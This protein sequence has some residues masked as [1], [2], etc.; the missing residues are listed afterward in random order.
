MESGYTYFPGFDMYEPRETT[1]SLEKWQERM[2]KLSVDYAIYRFNSRRQKQIIKINR[3][4]DSYNGITDPK[5]MVWLNT[6]YG[7][8]NLT[9]YVDYRLART[10]VDLIRGE[11][12]DR[13]LNSTVYTINKDAQSE[14]LQTFEF[15]TGANAARPQLDKLAQAGY[16]VM[17][18][19]QIPQPDANGKFNELDVKTKNEVIMQYLLNSQIKKLDMKTKF[20]QNYLDCLTAAECYSKIYINDNGYLK[21]RDIDVRDALYEEIERDPFL[22]QSP[23]LGERRVMFIPDIITE[24]V[25][26]TKADRDYLYQI[27]NGPTTG[28]IT[29]LDG[30][31]NNFT[32]IGSGLAA[33]VYTIEWY[34]V[35]PFF[36]KVSPDKNG[37]DPYRKDIDANEYFSDKFQKR[38]KNESKKGVTIETKYKKVLWEATRISNDIYTDIREKANIIANIDN[39][40]ETTSSYSGCI[41]NMK[42]GTRVSLQESIENVSRTYNTVMFQINRELAKSKGKVVSY[43]MAALPK[44]KTLA[45]VIHGIT[46]DSLLIY[47][48]AEDGNMGNI[49]LNGDIGFKPFDLGISNTVGV[50][51][52]LK[53]QLQDT[54]D[55]LS[56][57]NEQREGNISASATVGNTQSALKSSRSIT[58]PMNYYFDRYVENVLMKTAEL[59][60][61]VWTTLHPEEGENI[62]G[63]DG[64]KF[65]RVTK[66]LL[67]DAFGVYL[68]DSRKEEEIR[69][70]VRG[71]FGASINAGEMAPH[72]AIEFE[73]EQTV[74]EA[75]QVVKKGW[76]TIQQIRANEQQNNLKA[77]AEMHQRDIEEMINNR[78]DIQQQEKDLLILQYRLK[79]GLVSQE[80]KNKYVTESMKTSAKTPIPTTQGGTV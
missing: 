57:V 43:D 13:P 62:V 39:P 29:G 66:D 54:A 8:K 74:G 22:L 17:D 76:E 78:E 34:S 46:N 21:F 26:L 9:S 63:T 45:D 38:L 41:V 73:L 52:N 60:K 59:T 67:F 58:E 19:M 25:N 20:S 75:V 65:L 18:G 12:L 31:R 4:F 28:P 14:K 70:M 35:K 72:T 79:S 32:L 64:I 80:G 53:M 10:K 1:D 23:Y 56:G 3:M 30:R 50:L 61:L 37:G 71:Y 55:R 24:F 48:S 7:K 40:F 42:D 49:A 44:N 11:W 36:T 69:Q 47:N 5:S 15:L 51:I 6:T 27:S 2:A 33:D 68:G 77:Q 16:D